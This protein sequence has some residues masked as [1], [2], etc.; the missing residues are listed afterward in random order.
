MYM[1]IK[2]GKYAIIVGGKPLTVSHSHILEQ[3]TKQ[4]SG[5]YYYCTL[6]ASLLIWN[7]NS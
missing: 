2:Q 1:Y 6:W 4:L 7:V 5:F 3:E